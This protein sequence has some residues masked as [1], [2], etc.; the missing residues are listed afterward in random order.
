V[1]LNFNKIDE[2]K[3]NVSLSHVKYIDEEARSAHEGGW[4]HILDKL[5]EVMQ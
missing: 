1:T 3:T 2:N 4:T 5:N